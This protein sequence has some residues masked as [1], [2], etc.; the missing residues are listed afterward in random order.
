MAV[1]EKVVLLA[2][3]AGYEFSIGPLLWLYMP[4]VMNDSGVRVGTNL[5][6]MFV[7]VI[8]LTTPQLAKLD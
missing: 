7:I 3:I 1:P 6:W 8:S 2:F 4:E 5:N